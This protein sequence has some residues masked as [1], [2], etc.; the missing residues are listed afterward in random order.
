MLIYQF[1]QARSSA[2]LERHLDMVEVVGSSPIVPILIM[3]E[4]LIE[5]KNIKIDSDQSIEDIVRKT[6]NYKDIVGAK[7]NG[8][9]V[10]LSDNI[11]SSC[12]IDLVKSSD[13][14][15]LEIIRH[16]CAHVFG[17]AIKQIYPNAQN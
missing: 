5:N 9:L 10:D 11:R 15:G 13:P 6:F 2:W 8:N 4:V 17:H 14:E 7:L 16:S 1:L 3:I 12:K